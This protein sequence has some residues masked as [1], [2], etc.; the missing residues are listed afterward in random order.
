MSVCLSLACC[1]CAT[2]ETVIPPRWTKGFYCASFVSL[3]LC[4]LTLRG[5]PAHLLTRIEG[6][7]LAAGFEGASSCQ[8][9]GEWD[10]QCLGR[11]AVYRVM[12]VS[13]VFH[14][15]MMLGLAGH[16]S[17]DPSRF[18]TKLQSGFWFVKI[19]LLLGMLVASF[20]IPH[21]DLERFATACKVLA[22]LFLLIQLVLLID[23]AYEWNES[24]VERGWF[25][26]VTA[27]AGLLLALWLT[28]VVL[29]FAWFARGHGC[30]LF[31]FFGSTSLL[32]PLAMVAAAIAAEHGALLTAA[33]VSVQV[34]YTIMSGCLGARSACNA[35]LTSGPAQSWSL[36]AGVAISILSV[37]WAAFSSGG[38]ADAFLLGNSSGGGAD[39]SAKRKQQ[40]AQL[41]A[42]ITYDPELGGGDTVPIAADGDAG[43]GA[44]AG[45]G[46]AS[47]HEGYHYSFFHF[48]FVL[49]SMYMAM[50]LSGWGADDRVE[51]YSIEQGRIGL[52]VRIASAWGTALVYLWTLAAPS[53]LRGR[54]F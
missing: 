27:S 43:A 16:T 9:A 31:A 41:R 46:A 42:A 50:L 48:I 5:D 33:V 49:S 36:I 11:L 21:A 40:R 39:S 15:L 30:G 13:T 14:T 32:L 20:F 18:R 8:I 1:W 10:T 29:T 34:S 12:F 35:R 54:E 47:G 24:W 2:R 37:A 51:E 28:L 6:T 4:A 25:R 17:G 23:F 19:V 26:A 44:G 22:P 45:A 3:T 7:K 53:I 52:W 38:S